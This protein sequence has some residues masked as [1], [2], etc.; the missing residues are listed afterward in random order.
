ME[1]KRVPLFVPILWWFTT[2]CWLAVVILDAA[3]GSFSVGLS[4][5]RAL[6]FLCSLAA[7]IANTVRY[8]AGRDH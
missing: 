7:A 4:L 5:L 1:K 8:R 6:A 3:H 2:A